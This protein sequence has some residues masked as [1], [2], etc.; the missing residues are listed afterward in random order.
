MSWFSD[1]A[2]NLAGSLLGSAGNGAI[3]SAYNAEMMEKQYQLNK[4]LFDYTTTHRYQ[5]TVQ[6]LKNA[7]LNPILAYGGLA[8]AS[9]G[10][11]VGLLGSDTNSPSGANSAQMVMQRRELKQRQPL[12]DAQT[13]QAS[14]AAQLAGAQQASVYSNIINQFMST[15][16]QIKESN[17]RIAYNNGVLGNMTAKTQAEISNMMGLLAVAQLNA[18]TNA[19]NA[20]TAEKNAQAYADWASQWILESGART[21]GLGYQNKRLGAQTSHYGLPGTDTAA[22]MG[23]IGYNIGRMLGG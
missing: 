1:F 15:A 16:Q 19:Q 17:N 8:G 20:R 13:E 23:E 6:D 18:G 11:S 7:G 22:Q 10:T 14:S 9:A 2:G 3:S 12:V 4:D 21:T 5:N